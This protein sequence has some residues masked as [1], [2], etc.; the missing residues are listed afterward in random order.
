MD[1]MMSLSAM[2]GILSMLVLCLQDS[3]VV[4]ELLKAE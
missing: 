3:G 4:L 2:L 1:P